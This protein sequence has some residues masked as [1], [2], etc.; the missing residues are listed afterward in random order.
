MKKLVVL[1]VG[2]VALQHIAFLVLE[3]FF[4]TAPIGLQTFGLTPEFA[5]QSA[6]LAANQGLYNGFLAAGLIWSLTAKD[7]GYDLKVFFLS[8]VILAGIF[9]AITAQISILFIQGAP[10]FV[11]LLAVVLTAN[12][13]SPE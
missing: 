8:C 7:R 5:E 6:S 10:A 12:R 2:F 4:W 9:G 11:A 3:I 13:P 1:L